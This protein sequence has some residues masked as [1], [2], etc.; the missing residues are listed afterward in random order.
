VGVVGGAPP[1]FPRVNADRKQRRR[2]QVN[3]RSRRSVGCVRAAGRL[4]L[5][6]TRYQP[7]A[8][9]NPASDTLS[10]FSQACGFVR[11][12]AHL[13]CRVS[14]SCCS[15][16]IDSAMSGGEGEASFGRLVRSSVGDLGLRSHRPPRRSLLGHAQPGRMFLWWWNTLWGSYSALTSASRR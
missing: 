8:I 16:A 12:M 15:S 7:I 1:C 6:R 14:Q 5:N 2:V 4:T 9:E 10:A 11:R 13:S 3:S